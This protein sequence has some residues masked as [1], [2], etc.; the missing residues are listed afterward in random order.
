MAQFVTGA[1]HGG[2]VLDFPAVL[3]LV[4]RRNWAMAQFRRRAAGR[5]TQSA[6]GAAPSDELRARF[7]RAGLAS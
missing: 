1:G 5:T 6:W 4:R 2:Q 3:A 7:P